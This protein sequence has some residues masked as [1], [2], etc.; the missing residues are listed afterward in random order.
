MD[1]LPERRFTRLRVLSAADQVANAIRTSINT[2]T[3]GY[4]EQLPSE[5][6]LASQLGVSRGTLR[7]ALQRLATEGLVEVRRGGRSGTFVTARRRS[8]MTVD[9]LVASRQLLEIPAVMAATKTSS[10]ERFG[11]LELAV[12]NLT[13]HSHEADANRD[14]HETLLDLSGNS[15]WTSMARPLFDWTDAHVDRT[16]LD[17]GGR[18]QMAQDHLRISRSICMGDGEKATAAMTEH[19]ERVAEIYGGAPAPSR[20]RRSRADQQVSNLIPAS[21]SR[22]V[23]A[24]Q[25]EAHPDHPA[26][27]RGPVR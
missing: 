16:A 5:E 19:L 25:D 23:S 7:A 14:F 3:W 27:G 4:G 15:L 10:R 18:C 13:D 1:V 17:G 20:G 21:A 9:G 22:A 8:P 6:E 2:L 12:R 24:S 26:Q 11:L